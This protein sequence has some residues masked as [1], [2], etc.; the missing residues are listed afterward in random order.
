MREGSIV[1]IAVLS[2]IDWRSTEK[3]ACVLKRLGVGEPWACAL[4]DAT[5]AAT[6]QWIVRLT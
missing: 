3:V 6:N 4:A 2:D 5:N 1:A